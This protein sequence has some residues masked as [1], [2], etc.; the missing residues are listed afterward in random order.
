M[1]KCDFCGFDLSPSENGLCGKCWGRL[2]Q[3]LGRRRWWHFW[4][5]RNYGKD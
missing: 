4:R 5:K 1:V 2:D 3:A